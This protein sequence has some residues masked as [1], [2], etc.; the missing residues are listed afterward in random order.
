MSTAGNDW[1]RDERDALDS[2]RDQLE[3]IR[4]RHQGDPP[5]DLLRAAKADVLPGELQGEVARHLSESAWSRALVEGLT[6]DEATLAPDASQRLLR[7]I[8]SAAAREH[9]GS[10]TRGW[11]RP[12]LLGSAVATAAIAWLLLRS[13]ADVPTS[14]APPAAIVAEGQPP[15]APPFQLAFEKPDV[16]LSMAAL[17]W[18]GTS[19]DNQLLADLKPAFDAYRQGDYAS[20]ERE[21]TALSERYPSTIEIL[22][23]QGVSRLYLDDAAGA[24]TA[25]AAAAGVADSTFIS[26]VRWYLAV[27]E[28]R[29]GNVADARARLDALCREKAADAARA[30]A[31]LEQL[32]SSP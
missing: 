2:V 3:A 32:E 1:D 20:A 8:K 29:A 4:E 9:Q 25:L 15:A 22:F 24:R 30:C 19:G 5:L 23:Y 7:R 6:P 28:Q 27:A 12:L 26:D 17:T 14:P 31:A 10:S 18:R 16:R 13:P 21:L 11:L